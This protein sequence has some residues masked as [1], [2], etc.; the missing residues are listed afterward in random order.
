LALFEEGHPAS[1]VEELDFS[2]VIRVK[3]EVG[4]ADAGGV[5]RRRDEVLASLEGQA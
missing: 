4:P 2:G 3:D 1:M 5:E